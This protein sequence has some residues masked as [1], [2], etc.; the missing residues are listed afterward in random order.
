MEQLFYNRRRDFL[1]KTSKYLRYVLND[2][3]V[4]V[5]LVLLGF[6]LVQY[7]Y[8]LDHFP[9]NPLGIWIV[10]GLILIISLGLGSIATY[11]EPADK[12]FLMVKEDEIL[13]IIHKAMI[14]AFIFWGAVQLIILMI[15]VPIFLALGFLHFHLGIIAILLLLIKYAIVKKKASR[16]LTQGHLN[17]DGLITYEL[18]RKQSILKFYSLFTT[19]KGLTT[20]V[21]RRS[22]LDGLL[23]KTPK[24]HEKT[25]F[26]L[27]VRAFLRS[28]D[29]LGLAVRLIILS[30]M[31]LLFVSNPTI[32]VGLAI[33][34]NY[35]LLFQLLTIFHHFDYH[36]LTTTY[37]IDS[38]LKV[39]NM[40]FFLR[41]LMLI[42]LAIELPFSSSILGAFLL[43][44]SSLLM[45]ELYL[46]YKVKQMID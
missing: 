1:E 27:F 14:R 39:Q 33:L 37:P 2:H 21:K 46:R 12:Q 35:L 25:W 31:S 18:K 3:F 7:R 20:S 17:W 26:Y 32:S 22:Y 13:V 34:F 44:G 29:Y 9:E 4:L 45:S 8:L 23:N 5:L 41:G 38:S 15:L 24:H 6:M 11:V 42:L 36:Y 16:F 43:I 19:V 28:G 40:I 10:I 30:M